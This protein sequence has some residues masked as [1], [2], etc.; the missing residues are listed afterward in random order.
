MSEVHD[1]SIARLLVEA[2]LQFASSLP[3][4]TAELE[5]LLAREAWD[6]LRRA[7]HKL[8][9]SSGTY[10]FAEVSAAAGAIEEALL[11]A[12]LAPGAEARKLL[13]EQA[14]RASVEAARAADGGNA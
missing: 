7:A 10:G 6:E 9:G 13:A 11:A 8:R 3:A 5:A 14:R 1:P 12:S 4:K 2:R